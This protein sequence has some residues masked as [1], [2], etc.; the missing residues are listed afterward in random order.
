V[1]LEQMSWINVA[2]SSKPSKFIMGEYYKGGFKA[3][4][5]QVTLKVQ[6]T[7]YPESCVSFYQTTRRHKSHVFA[8]MDVR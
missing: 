6:A 7:N 8:G 5:M 3:N 1:S 4:V 2:L